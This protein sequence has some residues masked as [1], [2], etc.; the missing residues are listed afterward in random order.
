VKNQSVIPMRF[1][2]LK[3]PV[4]FAINGMMWDSESVILKIIATVKA[5]FTIAKYDSTIPHRA[6]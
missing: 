2:K 5:L 4:L 3:I 6:T 1:R